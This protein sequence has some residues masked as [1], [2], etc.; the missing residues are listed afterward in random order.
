MAA[1]GATPQVASTYL[2]AHGSPEAAAERYLRDRD[3][4]RPRRA[5]RGAAPKREPATP[6]RRPA[7]RR[8]ADKGAAA[9]TK[10][11][12]VDDDEAAPL[13]QGVDDE[14]A[15]WR[16]CVCG[17]SY[18]GEMVACEGGCDNW[19]HFA[20]VGLTRLPRGEWL[21]QDCK[22]KK[23]KKRRVEKPP[24]PLPPPPAEATAG[25]GG[26]GSGCFSTRRFFGFFF[27][28]QSWQSHSPRGKRVRPTQAKWNQLS[29]PP[30]HATISP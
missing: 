3:G 26:S 30:S 7:K 11:A 25:G 13:V 24:A 16:G 1:V 19:F 9:G 15:D 14:W 12:T 22:T 29:Q 2:D 8:R 20:C 10:A 4:D 6:P 5:A 28:L 21:C 18:Y 27:V 23:T 17:G